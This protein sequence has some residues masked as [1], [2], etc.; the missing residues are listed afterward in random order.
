[1]STAPVKADLTRVLEE[2]V[3]RANI[4]AEACQ[5]L[6]LAAQY[7]GDSATVGRY[8]RI[9]NN[10]VMRGETCEPGSTSGR[11][12]VKRW[13]AIAGLNEIVNTRCEYGSIDSQWTLRGGKLLLIR[14]GNKCMSSSGSMI[15][16]VDGTSVAASAVPIRWY[17][18]KYIGY[19]PNSLSK[20]CSYE[21]IT[22]SSQSSPSQAGA[23][24]SLKKLF[25]DLFSK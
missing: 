7:V 11:S 12:G 21:Y 13:E 18:Y 4:S 8:F 15:T 22:S 1:M 6:G 25:T 14:K 23:G 5:T 17:C 10:I 24:F 20:D 16:E 2:N 19:N 3:R 9:V